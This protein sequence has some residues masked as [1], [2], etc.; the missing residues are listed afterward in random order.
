MTADEHVDTVVVGS[1]FGGAVAAYRLADGGRSV[2]VL[3][4]GKAYPPGSFPRSPREMS[5]AFWD[6]DARTYGLFDVWSFD[7]FESIVSSGLGGGSLIYANV[8]LRKD[9]KWFVHEDPL[10][11]GGYE[12]WPVTRADLDPHYDAVEEMLGATRYPYS[13]TSKTMAMQEAAERLDL[14]W[15]R[16]PLAVSFAPRPGAVPAP[17]LPLAGT[18]YPNLHDVPR[19]TCDLGGGCDIGCNEGA[20]NS[21]DHT[22]LSAAKHHGADLRTLCEVRDVHA[23]DGGG[24]VVRYLR[25]HPGSLP[26]WRRITADHVVLG[27]GTYGTTYLLLRSRHLLPQLGAA[28]GTRF[29]GNGD[30][31]AFLMPGEQADERIFD[32]STGPVI[33]SAIRGDDGTARG[34]YVEDGGYPGFVDWMVDTAGAAQAVRTLEFVGEWLGRRRHRSEDPRISAEVARMIGNGS[35]SSGSLPL[36]G[37]GRDVPDGVMSLEDDR[38]AVDWTTETSRSFFDGVLETMND[39]AE[40]L[41]TTLRENPLAFFQRAVTVHPLGGAPMGHD[42]GSGVCDDLGQVFGHPGLYI[43]DGAA[44]PGP[45]GT[46][47]SLTI[48]AH[49]DRLA[50]GILDGRPPRSVPRHRPVGRSEP[51]AGLSFTERMRGRLA[52]GETDPETGATTGQEITV[53]LTITIDDVAAF[54]ADPHH[55]ATARGWVESGAIGGRRMR[56]NR[57]WFNLFVPGPDD[58]S[59]RMVYRLPVVDG[60]GTRRTFVGHKE[61][62]DDEGADLWP[63]T[64]TLFTRLLD[65]HIGE[66]PAADP[67][68][69]AATVTGAGVVRIGQIDLLNQLRSFRTTGPDGAETLLRFARFFVGSLWDVYAG[70]P[71]SG[72]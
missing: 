31:L 3:E 26:E 20:K 11:D 12:T 27:A 4:R 72:E 47:P 22:Y 59:R 39:I 53:Q 14:H 44:M 48:A 6:P 61:V 21:L 9:E 40:E 57:G 64:T 46:N 63:D 5:T 52:L 43:A 29:S 54:V 66:P 28:L 70:P 7:G 37:M 45:V 42:P 35:L 49:A 25:H 36:L 71:T 10:P 51:R 24:Y 18:P 60:D 15:E 67:E 33:T 1:G 68:Q 8:L 2:V 62:R 13:R 30:L 32:A 16:A 58:G 69:D 19:R 65:G 41:G 17:G 56:V 34:F 50:T 55:L 38:L 23:L